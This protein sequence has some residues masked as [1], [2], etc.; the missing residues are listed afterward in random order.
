MII[1][2]LTKGLIETPQYSAFK[3]PGGEIHFKFKGSEE[4]LKHISNDGNKAIRILVRLNTSDDIILLAIVIDT[5]RKEGKLD[6]TIEVF[7]PYMPYQQADRNFG[8][9]E[10]FS[11]KTI[12]NFLNSLD[13]NEYQ[14]FDPHSDVS[15]ALLDSKVIPNYEFIKSVLNNF[16][17]DPILLSPDAGAYKKIYKLADAIGFKGEIASANKSRSLSTGNIDSLELSRQD[18]EGK[19]VLIIDDICIGGRT[20]TALAEKLRERNVG[21]LYLAVSHGIFSNGFEELKKHF[22]KVFTTNS[23]TNNHFGSGSFVTYYKII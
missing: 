22:D 12:C 6:Q 17:I 11:L 4:Y 2:D 20:F 5:I 7:I 8:V 1:L 18:F 16:D 9:G 21:K 15:A 10:C 14:I 19:D 3:F 23:R 13:V